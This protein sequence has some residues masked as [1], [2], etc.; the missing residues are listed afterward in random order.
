[1]NLGTICRANWFA[2]RSFE[3]GNFDAL[4]TICK[5]N[6]VLP[7]ATAVVTLVVTKD[8]KQG[9][10]TPL[11]TVGLLKACSKVLG[12]G[13]HQAFSVAKFLIPTHREYKISKFI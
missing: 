10:P 11:I 6:K 2:G 4:V 8:T 13:P 1:M 12:I 3:R 5:G 7:P 9:R